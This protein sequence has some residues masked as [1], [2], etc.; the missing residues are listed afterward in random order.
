[1][2]KGR[3]QAEAVKINQLIAKGS[4]HR[5]YALKLQQLRLGNLTASTKGIFTL[6]TFHISMSK[7]AYHR[8]HGRYKKSSIGRAKMWRNILQN[9]S[10]TQFALVG[11]CEFEVPHYILVTWKCRLCAARLR[12]GQMASTCAYTLTTV[13]LKSQMVC[14][15]HYETDQGIVYTILMINTHNL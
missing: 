13:L 11:Q 7:H 5:L 2:S 10:D 12:H 8:L 9:W 6:A 15:W 3:Q 1:M 4:E 14:D